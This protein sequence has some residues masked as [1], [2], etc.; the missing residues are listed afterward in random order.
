LRL[1]S[2][3][4]QFFFDGKDGVADRCDSFALAPMMP[5]SPLMLIS[6]QNQDPPLR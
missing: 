6:S 4:H 5:P 1:S 3:D 2:E